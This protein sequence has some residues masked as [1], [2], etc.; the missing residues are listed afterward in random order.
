MSI[1]S[2]VRGRAG[3]LNQ[4]GNK[5]AR[6]ASASPLV[7]TMTRLG[8]VVRGLV[9]GVIGVLAFQVAIGTGGGLNDTQGAI[10]ALS[11][12]PLGASLL[13]FILVGLVGY[14]LWGVIRAGLDS[15]SGS[16]GL[17]EIVERV[18]YAVSAISYAL[19][20][21]ATYGVITAKATAAHNGAQGAQA[22]QT[23]AS[24]LSNSWGPWV[25]GLA[26]LIIIGIGAAQ[27]VQ[28]LHADFTK[29]FEVYAL[30]SYRRT[31]IDRPGR[32][33]TA[34]RGVVVT[35]VGVFL[36]LAGYHHD[37][38]LAKGIDGVLTALLHQPSGPWLLGIVALGLVA[39][40]LYSALSGFWLRRKS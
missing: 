2:T 11:R 26:G 33:G 36:F 13:Y 18:G 8:Y 12:T 5:A 7:E 9:Y 19:L 24:I 29:Q 17:K 28:G 30:S 32:F 23:T 14:S 25:I 39:F 35:L 20:A 40:G 37:P 4:K 6:S 22:Q 1:R 21:Y 10:S 27:I 16:S 31:W 15:P 38:T 34:A 3:N